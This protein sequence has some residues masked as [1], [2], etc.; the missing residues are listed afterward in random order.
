M[1][2]WVVI[3]GHTVK[4]SPG[5][6]AVVLYSCEVG[7]QGPGGEKTGR[8]VLR[9]YSDF[10]TLAHT[11]RQEL[12]Q[13]KLLPPVPAKQR[14]TRVND[15]ESQI[16]ERRRALEAWLWDLL[17]DTTIAHSK[18]LTGFL[19]L[20]AARRGLAV[21]A[22]A[23]TEGLEAITDAEVASAEAKAAQAVAGADVPPVEVSARVSGQLADVGG[24]G[25]R[26]ADAGVHKASP[27]VHPAGRVDPALPLRA[28]ERSTLLQTMS[29]AHG[30]CTRCAR[31]AP[32]EVLYVG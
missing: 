30:I 28:D 17:L 19:E 8:T 3:P 10:R 13:D 4:A 22:S 6:E 9:R 5:G 11:L 1:S 14:L 31:V 12:G 7:V 24:D 23:V 25:R 2:F 32:Q 27:P 15:S 26:Q 29:G 20:S 18:A 21:Q 16:A